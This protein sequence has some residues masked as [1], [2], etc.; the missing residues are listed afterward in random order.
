MKLSKLLVAVAI[1]T[2]ACAASAADDVWA[3][4]ELV[5]TNGEYP[6]PS[7]KVNDEG[8]IFISYYLDSDSAVKCAVWDGSDWTHQTVGAS[9]GGYTSLDLGPGGSPRIAFETGG[10]VRYARWNGASWNVQTVG[11]GTFNTNSALA[12]DDGDNAHIAYVDG[13]DVRYAYSTGGGWGFETVDTGI[14]QGASLALD[15]SDRPHV[16]YEARPPSG[17]AEVRYSMR[18]GAGWSSP[19][20]AGTTAALGCTSLCL[21]TGDVPHVAYRADGQTMIHATAAGGGWTSETVEAEDEA[22]IDWAPSLL[23]DGQDHL[24]LSYRGLPSADASYGLKYAK[25]TGAG[26]ELDVVQSAPHWTFRYASLAADAND[27]IHAAYT[28][29]ADSWPRPGLVYAR[30]NPQWI[31]FAVAEEYGQSEEYGLFAA[32]ATGANAE[33]CSSVSTADWGPDGMLYAFGYDTQEIL[34]V[35]PHTGERRGVFAGD[36]VADEESDLC[37]GGEGSVFLWDDDSDS[38]LHFNAGGTLIA[39]VPHPTLNTSLGLTAGPDGRVYIA[40]KYGDCVIGYDPT[41]QQFTG[42]FADEG[43]LDRPGDVVFGPDGNLYVTSLGTDEVLRYDGETGGFIDAFVPSHCG[44]SIGPGIAFGSDGDLYVSHGTYVDRYD[45][46]TGAYL[47]ELFELP[48]TCSHL[49]PVPEPTTLA[50]LGIGGLVLARRRRR[51]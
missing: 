42:T 29:P 51:G 9:A 13:S 26:W 32:S 46:L 41:T 33:T 5:L 39:Q 34:R 49:V 22:G 30:R 23:A 44:P 17:D 21:T 37:V 48:D 24:H 35:D 40:D 10:D 8:S 4:K 14:C 25:N 16:S 19:A 6:Y 11:S 12:V 47:G 15:G 31:V 28:Y 7:V 1:L 3:Y 18:S 20:L 43:G 38:I 2:T 27:G 45:G 50:L 36:V